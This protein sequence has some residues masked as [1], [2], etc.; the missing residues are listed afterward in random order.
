MGSARAVYA[1]AATMTSLGWGMLYAFASKHISYDLGGG[2]DA[3][4][5]FV[6][7]NWLF[8]VASVF[9]GALA[10]V[11]GARNIV[12]A[13]LLNSVLILLATA[14][15]EPYTLSVVIALTALPWALSWP[16]VLNAVFSRARGG[17]GQEYSLFTIGSGVGLMLGSLMS[18]F[19]CNIGGESL[20]YVLSA[21]MVSLP[22]AF[23]YALY[24]DSGD[25]DRG[26]G[27][28]VTEA[29]KILRLGLVAVTLASFSREL[30]FSFGPEKLSKELESLVAGNQKLLSILYGA[31]YAGGALVSPIAR[32]A[33]GRIADRYGAKKLYIASILSYTAFYWAFISSKGVVPLILWQIPLYPFQDT[34]VNTYIASRTPEKLRV[35]AFGLLTAF[36]SIGGFLVAIVPILGLGD[37]MKSGAIITI[38]SV[39]AITL[40]LYEGRS[41]ED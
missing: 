38:A 12:L 2:T 33:A 14:I 26:D 32:L 19:L 21:L 23:F 13:G 8:T 4:M 3:Y 41:G 35:S 18:G 31:V 39:I 25:G 40:L 37:A 29:F 27:G 10:R 24:P 20:V 1:I 30:A 11:L 17:L 28:G 36:T 22:F 9:S 7:L 34:A 15:H 16:S 5:V 6:G